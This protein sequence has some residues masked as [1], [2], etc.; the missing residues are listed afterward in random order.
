[1]HRFFTKP[2]NVCNNK[3][4]LCG[5]DVI[6]IKTVLRL[7]SGDRIQVLDGCG[8]SYTVFLTKIMSKEIECC[9]DFKESADDCESP[10]SIILGQ[11]IVK[12]T[13]F[14]GIVRR[15]VELGVCKIDPII[16]KRCISRLP[17]KDTIK[18]NERWQRIAREAAKQCGRSR[19]PAI[20]LKP[21]SVKEFCYANRDSDLKLIFWEEEK[22][23]KIRDLPR[24]ERIK[25]LAVLIGPE[26]GFS[27]DEIGN[28][29][30][31]GFQS[32]SLGSRLLKTDTATLAILSI[33]QNSWGDL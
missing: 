33:L 11:G 29:V 31:Y 30:E 20:S 32:I 6:H 12:G 24:A 19:I 18:K 3:I 16:A 21:K 2:E 25:S 17:P 8:N 10:L 4:I 13:G 5:T 15:A 22:F 26:G 14:D 28:A 27:S 1:M 9:I 7:K 23:I